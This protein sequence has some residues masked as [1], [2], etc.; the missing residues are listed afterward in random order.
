MAILI[1]EIHFKASEKKSIRLG[2][3]LIG[4]PEKKHGGGGGGLFFKNAI[5]IVFSGVS[6][7]IRVAG[8]NVTKK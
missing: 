7:Q 1:T 5:F 6:L 4:I 8:A 3:E 2:V